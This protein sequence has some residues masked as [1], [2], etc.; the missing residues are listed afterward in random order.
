MYTD[1]KVSS[2]PDRYGRKLLL[3]ICDSFSNDSWV[4]S[5]KDR[6]S[7][8]VIEA[9]KDFQVQELGDCKLKKLMMDN[10]SCFRSD[11]MKQF[12]VDNDTTRICSCA[13]HQHQNGVAESLWARLLPL[14]IIHMQSAPWLGVEFWVHAMKYANEQMRWRPLKANPDHEVPRYRFRGTPG[15]N[16]HDT[17][18]FRRWGCVAYVHDNKAKG[19]NVRAKKGFL[20]GIS[21]YHAKGVYSVYMPE[22]QKIVETMNV[23]FHDNDDPQPA[24]MPDTMEFDLKTLKPTE[25]INDCPRCTHEMSAVPV[26]ATGATS[27]TANES[28]LSR[29]KSPLNAVVSTGNL[30]SVRSDGIKTRCRALDGKTVLEALHMTY[31]HGTG[32][33]N[34]KIADLHYDAAASNVYITI[35]GG[36]VVHD[37]APTVLATFSTMPLEEV[38]THVDGVGTDTL[39]SHFFTDDAINAV[40]TYADL[41]PLVA[42]EK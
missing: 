2:T 41:D 24:R 17:S 31:K 9:F 37:D 34:Y 40:E 1:I 16:K 22:T 6:S 23:I 39:S 29:C 7:K 36:G 10:D 30:S 14:A 19:V 8:S 12:L 42:G 18:Y 20:V 11:E 3:G 35:P 21:D 13:Y 15:N 28:N 27:T 33:K 38:R 4:Y 5:L 32:M 26:S 25:P